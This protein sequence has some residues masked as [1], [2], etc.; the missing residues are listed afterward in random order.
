MSRLSR[1]TALKIAAAIVLVT[2]AYS[3]VYSVSVLWRGAEAIKEA[4]DLPPYFI[5]V[6]VL[7]LAPIQ[8]IGAIGAWR[9]QRW[10]VVLLLLAAA[11]DMLSAA[12]GILFAPTTTLRLLAS[13]GMLLDLAV[14][15]LCL[16]RDRPMAAP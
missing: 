14:I 4:G 8:I 13:S 3:F 5:L 7:I 12:P 16:W 1:A 2:G 10:G 11:V 9:G 15:I 6:L